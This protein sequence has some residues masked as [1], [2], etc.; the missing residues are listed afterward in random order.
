MAYEYPELMYWDNVEKM[1]H[2]KKE[3]L[4]FGRMRSHCGGNLKRTRGS[5][6]FDCNHPK[7]CQKC[8]EALDNEG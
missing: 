7:V 3:H 1:Y 4:S 6:Y 5:E 2:T 8:V